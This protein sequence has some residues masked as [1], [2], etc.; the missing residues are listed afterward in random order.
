MSL[1]ESGRAMTASPA[2]VR[3]AARK[4]ATVVR[5]REHEK[6][7]DVP[8]SDRAGRLLAASGVVKAWPSPRPGRWTLKASDTVGAL[9]IADLEL[10]IEPK[11]GVNRLLFLLGYR[12]GWYG[13]QD[14]TVGV[15][16]APDLL[17][18]V[19]DAFGRAAEIALRDGPIHGYRRVEEALPEARGRLLIDAQIRKR[20]GLP[21]P[22]EV[23]YNEFSIDIAENRILAAAAARLL[24]LPGISV[25]ARTHLR[26]TRQRLIGVT[27]LPAAA[28]VAMPLPAWHPTRLNA[29]YHPALCLAEL[30]LRGGSFELETGS[31]RV[32]GFL[33]DMNRVFED[34][35]IGSLGEALRALGGRIK[36]QD[37]AYH[38][39]TAKQVRLKPDLVW[40][41]PDSRVIGV[42][43]A[44]YKAD[45]EGRYP[46]G[47]LYQ[48]LAYCTRLGLGHGHLIY[49][50]G[51]QASAALHVAN[52]DIAITRHALNLETT[53]TLLL[54]QIAAIAGRMAACLSEA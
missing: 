47:D 15:E 46:E 16:E 11:I 8:L 26:R 23:S 27:P 29:H 34:F 19:A 21:L 41:A 12:T 3:T 40:Y 6:R 25:Q 44:K 22:L 17:A 10:R 53:P 48:M 43:D 49:A 31:V 36:P 14:G 54:A 24:G 35:V 4:P 42:A 2:D 28:P 7:A 50:A 37:A 30:V 45:S 39:D 33:L 13:W 32:D 20:H 5:L 51:P 52:T 38:L 18:S 9:R 1:V